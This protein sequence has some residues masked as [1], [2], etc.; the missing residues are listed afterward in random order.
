MAF[1]GVDQLGR[2]NVEDRDDAVDGTASD[3]FAIRGLKNR[4]PN[5]TSDTNKFHSKPP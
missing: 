4:S 5:E 3:I 1:K 2:D